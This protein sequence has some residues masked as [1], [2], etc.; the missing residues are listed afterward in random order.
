MAITNWRTIEFYDGEWWDA[1]YNLLN[2]TVNNTPTVNE[3]TT[4][5]VEVTS[6]TTTYS[7]VPW[8]T[9]SPEEVFKMQSTWYYNQWDNVMWDAFNELRKWSD[10]YSTTAK[11]INSF[12]DAL[13]NNYMSWEQWLSDAKYALAKQLTNDMA[14]QRDYYMS[15]F[16][17]EWSLTKEV[18]K[19]YDDLWNYLQTDAGRQAATIAAQGVHSGASLGAIRAQQNEAY[20]ESFGRYVKAKE[21]EITAK[22]Q[23]A[24]NLINFMSK[25]REEYWNTTNTYLISQ[26]QRAQDLLNTLY[27]NKAWANIEIAQWQLNKQISWGSWSS[28]KTTQSV[29]DM[30]LLALA[31]S[32]LDQQLFQQGIDSDTYKAQHPTEYTTLLRN[33]YNQ[34]ALA[35]KQ[36]VISDPV[37]NS[38]TGTTDTATNTS[39][40]DKTYLNR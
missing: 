23:I 13:Q 4:S 15:M 3:W 26:Y 33:M 24:T 21:Q 25:L 27:A 2:S 40:W 17:P 31:R 28:S 11:K 5:N 38:S 10:A 16:W 36:P 34:Y 30:N 18:N 37:V 7:P 22:Q 14:S 20:N 29:W 6:P 19:Y 8:S 1:L 39:D 35:Y 9:F 12:Y 32:N